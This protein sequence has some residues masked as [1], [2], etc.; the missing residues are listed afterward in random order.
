MA[1]SWLTVVPNLADPEVL[2]QPDLHAG[3]IAALSVARAHVGSL[4]IVDDLAGRNT[5]AKLGIRF[6]GTAGTIIRAKRLGIIPVAAWVLDELAAHGFRLGVD[7]RQRLLEH[8]GE[9]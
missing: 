9:Q 4:L 1:L 7:I 6:I 8:I 5:A 3:G 2:R